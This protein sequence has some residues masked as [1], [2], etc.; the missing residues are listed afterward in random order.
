M[1]TKMLLLAAL[2][3]TAAMSANAGLRFGFSIGLPVVVTPPVV[4]T[5][6]VAPAPVAVVET[7]PACPGLDY[8]WTHGYWSY[9]TSGYAWVSG[10]WQ[11][12]PVSRAH[13]YDWYR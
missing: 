10:A 3:G 9:R 4:Y 13:H 5:A 11:H 6:P 12:R 2:V 8:A 1:K 7:A